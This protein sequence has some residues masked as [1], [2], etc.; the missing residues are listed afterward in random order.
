[1]GQGRQ[2]RRIEAAMKTQRRKFLGLMAG[3]AAL[4]VLPRAASADAYPMRPVRI[5]VGY[6]AGIA[7][8]IFSRLAA[9]GLSERL[10][11]NFI[12][13]NRPGANSKIATGMGG[14]AAPDGY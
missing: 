1:M 4:P 7:P 14:R 6:P 8:D 11:Q 3:A 12:V 10:G 9:Q 13:D 2:V 5:L